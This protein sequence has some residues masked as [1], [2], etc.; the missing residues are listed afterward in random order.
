MVRAQSGD[1]QELARRVAQLEGALPQ[2][3]SCY[4]ASNT[5]SPSLVTTPGTNTASRSSA[6][7]TNT[8]NT[9]ESQVT[10]PCDVDT[11][12]RSLH[13]AA[14]HLGPHW[15]FNGVPIFS[16]EGQ[17]WVSSR[18][19]QQVQWDDF[20]F[21]VYRSTSLSPL[22]LHKGDASFLD[23]ID[24]NSAQRI[25]RTFF[26]SHATGAFTVIDPVLLETTIEKVYEDVDDPLSSPKHVSARACMLAALAVAGQMGTSCADLLCADTERLYHEAQ[27]IVALRPGYM[28][29]ETLVTALLLVS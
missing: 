7:D 15:F 23:L 10:S 14:R 18:T 22:Y 9:V 8:P 26:G 19:G 20:R 4:A 1:V 6:W 3:V 25:I 16:D 11:S 2:P 29:I 5:A 28:S 17:Q 12:N 13:S 27:R 21:P 24:R